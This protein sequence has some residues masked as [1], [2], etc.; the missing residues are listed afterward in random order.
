MR[1]VEP[2]KVIAAALD[3]V[4]PAAEAKNINITVRLD[5]SAGPVSGDAERLQQVIWNLLANAI[6]FTPERGRVEISSR[7]ADSSIEIE[8]A[9]S[10]QGISE[11]F[12]PYVF[13]RF[14]QADISTTRAHGGLG[15]G[16]AIVRHLVEMHGGTVRAES[17]G[18][19]KGATFIVRLPVQMDRSRRPSI[20]RFEEEADGRS[21]AALE[22]SQI[23]KGLRILIVDDDFDGREFL[24]AA[25]AQC[26]AKA[27]ASASA[28]D[29]LTQMDQ[30]KPDV[31][32]ADIGMPGEDGYSLI[33]QVRA[34]S[35]DRGGLTPAIALTAFAGDANRRR[36]IEAGYQKHMA[37]PAEP[38][39][40]AA[41]IARLGRRP[42]G[43]MLRSA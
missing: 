19:G 22:A 20:A 26:G 42:D 30:F 1:E 40:L 3:V 33:R 27:R 28:D 2:A 31:L 32:V 38:E 11:E 5:P 8:V 35:I 34:R 21:E 36:A 23:L 41:A 13:E 6:K 24:L 15:L 7:W 29:A 10:G 43:P 18:K 16:L 37:K 4:R 17:A 12:L 9:D 25:L 14:R 39:K